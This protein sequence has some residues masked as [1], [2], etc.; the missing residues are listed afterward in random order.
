MGDRVEGPGPM[1]SIMEHARGA[2]R[3]V[4]R[5]HFHATFPRGWGWG[6]GAFIADRL[7]RT[8]TGG[9]DDA[10]YAGGAAPGPAMLLPGD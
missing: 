2:G 1:E 3:S 8:G 4:P 10:S 7:A 6:R 9:N 5:F